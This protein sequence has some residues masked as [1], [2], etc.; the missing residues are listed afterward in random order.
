MATAT[1][2]I[3]V[4]IKGQNKSLNDA[5]KE[6]SAEL[7]ALAG[8]TSKATTETEKLSSA[9][10]KI[11]TEARNM[12]EA[13]RIAADSVGLLGIESGE[14]VA[15]LYMARDAAADFT[16]SIGGMKL[17]LVGGLGLTAGFAGLSFLKE[18]V[19]DAMAGEQ[20]TAQLNNALKRTPE[21]AKQTNEAIEAGAAGWAHYGQGVAEVKAAVAKGAALGIDPKVILDNRKGVEDLAHAMGGDLMTA[22]SSLTAGGER[23]GRSLRLLNLSMVEQQRLSKQLAY[24]QD[25]TARFKMITAAIENSGLAG[26]ADA[27]A[28]TAQGKFLAFNKSLENLRETVGTNLLPVVTDMATAL[29]G[30]VAGAN[31]AL[32]AF[33]GLGNFLQ[34]TWRPILIG[35]TLL[36]VGLKLA[37]TQLGQFLKSTFLGDV[38]ESAG[39]LADEGIQAA[40]AADALNSIPKEVM[41]TAAFTAVTASGFKDAYLLNIARIPGAIVPGLAV[42]PNPITVPEFLPLTAEKTLGTYETEL[43]AIP[44]V[45]P[46]TTTFAPALIPVLAISAVATVG[47]V[48]I[49]DGALNPLKD[50]IGHMIAQITGAHVADGVTADKAIDATANVNKA[51]VKTGTI[52]TVDGTVRVGTVT[53]P[54][55]ESVTITADAKVAHIILPKGT[56]LNVETATVHSITVPK[57]TTVQVAGNA[58]INGVSVSPGKTLTISGVHGTATIDNVVAARGKTLSIGA[59]HGTA[60]IDGVT[61]APGKTLEI[62]NVH[63]TAI[64]EN[65]I[66]APGKSLTISNV[67]GTAMIDNMSVAKGRTLTISNVH[68]TATIDGA[69]VA[70]GKR[71]SVTNIHGTAYIDNVIPAAGKHLTITGVNGTAVIDGVTLKKGAKVDVTGGTASIDILQV[72]G[73]K[74]NPGAI[75]SAL[76]FDKNKPVPYYIKY[77][78]VNQPPPPP[79]AKG[80]GGGGGGGGNGLVDT[81]V[82]VGVGL[83]ESIV[84]TLLLRKF[85][86]GGG[87][88][89]GTGGGGT[90]AP[91]GDINKQVDSLIESLDGTTKTVGSGAAAGTGAQAKKLID[92]LLGGADAPKAKDISYIDPSLF[93]AQ[94]GTAFNTAIKGMNLAAP[95]GLAF[96]G[97]LASAKFTSQLKLTLPTIDLSKT[98]LTLPTID[99]SKTKLTLPTFDVGKMFSGINS[100]LVAEGPKIGLVLVAAIVAGLLHQQ[101]PSAVAKMAGIAGGPT[102]YD[103][104]GGGIKRPTKK[105]EQAMIAANEAPFKALGSWINSNIINGIKS[106][107]SVF[108]DIGA[109]I[110]TA[111]KNAITSVHIPG[112]TTGTG[113]TPHPN[114]PKPDAGTGITNRHGRPEITSGGYYQYE[115]P[116]THKFIKD[117]KAPPHRSGNQDLFT[118]LP[119]SMAGGSTAHAVAAHHAAMAKPVV[120]HHAAAKHTTTIHQT[121]TFNVNGAKDPHAT[122]MEVQRALQSVASAAARKR[123]HGR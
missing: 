63:G 116:K 98:K 12:G 19:K 25:P 88:G 111:I 14:S 72:K 18:S 91:L 33:G 31:S 62:R 102:S 15:K 57:G 29:T 27:Q 51:I 48:L 89:G 112:V 37:H 13:V 1:S 60:T 100:F 26:A 122:A 96:A 50:A 65:V 40:K 5:L 30:M 123:Q 106:A 45:I 78:A 7:A 43:A 68:G 107:G 23:S 108:K 85:M 95:L 10:K 56:T 64:I 49:A 61:V 36:F 114:A 99:L 81:G 76:G 22:I 103:G 77:E 79:P 38:S 6:S 9:E 11:E 42:T 84:T 119:A 2:D 83:L 92:S 47:S 41:T 66:P 82:Q 75:G 109:W 34:A 24:T 32:G 28:G 8:G 52:V 113:G 21:I 74:I 71:L 73:V 87:G 117:G 118:P 17:A 16:R 97:A 67:H 3:M 94:L 115:D 80:G 105:Q 54:P 39:A 90:G 86:G 46:T 20:A 4:E 44:R 101:I 110:A 59:V 55:K 53:M 58:E 70:P 35:G 120:H 69:T 93:K 121:N 104:P